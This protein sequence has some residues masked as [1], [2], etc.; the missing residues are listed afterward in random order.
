MDTVKKEY[1]RL[2]IEVIFGYEDIVTASNEPPSDNAYE[3]PIVW[4]I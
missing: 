3:T 1:K 2:E 4:D